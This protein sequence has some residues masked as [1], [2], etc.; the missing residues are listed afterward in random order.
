MSIRSTDTVR[1]AGGEDVVRLLYRAF[2]DPASRASAVAALRTLYAGLDPRI[3]ESW[4]MAILTLNWYVLLGAIDDAYAIAGRVVGQLE[5]SGR[6]ISINL[7]AIWKPDLVAF[8]RDPR[9]HEFTARL[10]LPE[11]WK[12]HGPPDGYTLQDGRLVER[13]GRPLPT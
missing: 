2:G 3:A 10:G 5:R 12:A 11:Y 8:R 13:P 9:F 4:P 1:S 7:P 6:L